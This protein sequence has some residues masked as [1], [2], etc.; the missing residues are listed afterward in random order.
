MAV[1]DASAAA[2]GLATAG[3]AGSADFLAKTTADRVGALTTLWYLELFGAPVL[4]VL[5][6]II[7]GIPAPPFWAVVGLIA[8][9]SL[10]LLGLYFL[11]RAFQFGRLS[12]VAPLTS[13]YPAL[14]AVLSV[15]FLGERFVPLQVL[16]LV[17]TLAGIVTLASRQKS[18]P[19]SAR[20]SRAGVASALAAFIAFG[21]FY[22]GLKF[23]IGPVPPVTGAALTRLVG[24]AVVAPFMVKWGKRLSPPAGLRTRAT[25][26]P[27]LDSLSL[28]AFNLGVVLAGSIAVLT[29]ISG[30]YGAVTLGWAIGVLGERPD[31]I[32]WMGCALI[33][34]GVIVLTLL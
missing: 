9:S 5:A 25:L 3:G 17:A 21:L 29:T 18:N 1:G 10:S 23:V 8:L 32:Q 31:G 20:S 26:Y 22:F 7:D 33:F 13:G 4:V 14:T 27:V 16:G 15:V 12:I 2:Y 30:L 11:Y 28:V 24:L 19:T 6:L 34:L